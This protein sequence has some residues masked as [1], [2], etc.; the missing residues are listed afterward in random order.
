VVFLCIQECRKDGGSRFIE[1][2]VSFDIL[3]FP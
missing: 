2:G 3:R 1:D